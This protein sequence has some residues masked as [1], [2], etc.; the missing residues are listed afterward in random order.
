ML[1]EI[2]QCHSKLG[3]VYIQ[4]ISLR[5]DLFIREAVYNRQEALFVYLNENF[6]FDTPEDREEELKEILSLNLQ[7]KDFSTSVAAHQSF[8]NIEPTHLMLKAGLKDMSRLM[9]FEQFFFWLKDYKKEYQKTMTVLMKEDSCLS[10]EWKQYIAIMAVS[11][12]KNDF[13]FRELE[14]EFLICGGD[15]TWLIAGL[16]VVPSK[17][18]NISTLNDLIAHQPWKVQAEDITRLKQTWNWN[19]LIEATLI[20]IQFHKLSLIEEN[21]R[22]RQS[23][24]EKSSLN[25]EC[26]AE[27]I[28][29][30]AFASKIDSISKAD[31]LR[32]AEEIQKEENEVEDEAKPLN[33]NSLKQE[34]FKSNDSDKGGAEQDIILKEKMFSKHISPDNSKY[35]YQ[36]SPKEKTCTYLNF[37]WADNGIYALQNYYQTGVTCLDDEIQYIINLNSKM[38]GQSNNLISTTTIRRAITYYIE[39]LFGYYHEDYNYPNVSKLLDSKIKYTKYIKKI[40]CYPTKINNGD[41][42]ELAKV[43]AHEEILHIILLAALIKSRIQLTYLS[44]AINDVLKIID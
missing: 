38:E 16:N 21:L 43:F 11:T 39:S 1:T 13:L 3:K 32:L 28:K 23:I 34:S 9:Y 10:R 41:L 42:T 37:N 24:V 30:N 17:L 40:T 8:Y 12:M 44:R 31:V 18:K 29:E 14:E 33:K 26:L 36:G 19:E 27:N 5:K 4:S 22:I 15:E 2:D 7:H 35:I 20:M 6:Q 25:E